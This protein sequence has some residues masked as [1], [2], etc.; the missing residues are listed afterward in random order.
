MN[1]SAM[2]ADFARHTD[3][4]TFMLAGRYT[5]LEQGA[6]DELLPLCEERA[7][8]LV[9][10]GVFNSGLLARATPSADARYDYHDAPEAV[11]ARARELADAC[12]ELGTVLPAA[13][14]AFPLV[15][16]AVVSVCVGASS[17]AQ[18]DRSVDLY[19][20]GVPE[21]LW[22]SLRSAGLLA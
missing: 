12:A 1:Q 6:L 15:H 19:E 20:A 16:P 14:I 5:L 22:T 8:G 4:D 11:V 21:E 7:I 9:A 18:L 17:A 10:S 2:L 3:M 13:A